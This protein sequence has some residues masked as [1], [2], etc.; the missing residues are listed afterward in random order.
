MSEV[1]YP[2]APNGIYWTCQ[3]E[4]FLLGEPMVFVRLA[5][6]SVGCAECDTLYTVARRL[7]PAS[8]AQEVA[9]LLTARTSWVWLT[10]G[11]PLDQDV[12]PLLRALRQRVP[13][14]RI[15]L[16]TSGAHPL[17][18]FHSFDWVSVSPHG[19]PLKVRFADEVKLTFGL[20]G[21]TPESASELLE[22]E[23]PWF[24]HQYVQPLW[25]DAKSLEQSLA[26][27]KVR[28]GWRLSPQSHK[29]YN[30]A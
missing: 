10:G 4:G 15:A 27:V 24:R 13:G 14:A 23:R 9:S 16:A 25:G 7:A 20:N 11:E 2:I 3:G 17:P 1:T 19:G 21:F 5:G 30:L 18:E 29:L 26:W 12:V 8:I 6:C 22:K 28:A